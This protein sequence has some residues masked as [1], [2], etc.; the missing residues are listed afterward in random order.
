M[1]MN[2]RRAVQIE[3]YTE[4]F[5]DVITEMLQKDKYA[6]ITDLEYIR[7]EYQTNEQ[8]L[9]YYTPTVYFSSEQ[10]AELSDEDK[11]RFFDACSSGTSFRVA[12]NGD[13]HG[14]IHILSDGNEYTW[15]HGLMNEGALYKNGVNIYGT[16]SL[17]GKVSNYEYY[18]YWGL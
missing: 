2:H 7:T 15:R 13:N 1:Y 16:S 17:G 10:F 8:G 4:V 6:H 3:S 14:G 9:Q 5:C 18:R 11:T 12:V